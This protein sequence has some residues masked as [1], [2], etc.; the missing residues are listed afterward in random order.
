MRIYLKFMIVQNEQNI[1][2]L[3]RIKEI[4]WQKDYLTD[5]LNILLIESGL[6]LFS[7]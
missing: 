6:H 2:Q 1:L 3:I 4:I 5:E 7:D